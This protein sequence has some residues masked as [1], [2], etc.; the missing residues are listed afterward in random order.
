MIIWQNTN[1]EQRWEVAKHDM[2]LTPQAE[3][4]PKVVARRRTLAITLLS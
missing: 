1:R 3:Q 2:S 4:Y